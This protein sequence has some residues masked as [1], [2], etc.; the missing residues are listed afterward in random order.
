MLGN[1]FLSFCVEEVQKNTFS[2]SIKSRKISDL[3]EADVLIKVEY[4]SLNYKDALSAQG[5]K[6]ITRKYP[7]TP[8]IDAAGEVF[9]SKSDAFPIGTKVLVTGYDLGMNTSGGFQ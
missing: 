6:G 8:G 1:N 4:S 7:H 2:R 9:D 5:H 3:P